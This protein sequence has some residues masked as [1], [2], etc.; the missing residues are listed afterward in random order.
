[1]TYEKNEKVQ[2]M[3][4]GLWRNAFIDSVIEHLSNVNSAKK[5][6]IKFVND[7]SLHSVYEGIKI[8]LKSF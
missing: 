6:S 2:V 1:M 5:F 8:I 4:N 7:D 3:D